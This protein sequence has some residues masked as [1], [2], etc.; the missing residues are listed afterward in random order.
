MWAKGTRPPNNL[1]RV[2]RVVTREGGGEGGAG[3]AQREHWTETVGRWQA[4]EGY[5][6][7][8]N[9]P[10]EAG[11]GHGPGCG[12]HL[13]AAKQAGKPVR[14]RRRGWPAS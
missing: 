7:R 12:F 5:P 2:I 3:A 11:M 9:S 10:G 4:R 1:P 14:R 8:R 6:G 13:A